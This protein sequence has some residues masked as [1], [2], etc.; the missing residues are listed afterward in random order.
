M[1]A[2]LA[3]GRRHPAAARGLP[4]GLT[5]AHPDGRRRRPPAPGP[6]AAAAGSSSPCWSCSSRWAW[7]RSLW[8]SYKLVSRSR[9]ILELDQKTIQLD[10]AR[11]LSQQVAIYLKSLRAQVA[12]IARTLEVDVAAGAVR[13]GASQRIRE[14]RR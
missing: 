3:R 4:G 1:L 9:E 8:T 5:L 11:S 6:C 10:K 14:Q 13:R 7:C 12:A 2:S